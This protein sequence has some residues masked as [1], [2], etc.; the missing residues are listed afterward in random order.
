[1]SA[2]KIDLVGLLLVAI[3]VMVFLSLLPLVARI[4]A[5]TAVAHGGAA[6]ASNN[7]RFHPLQTFAV[8]VIWNP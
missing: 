6:T 8:T 5:W 4:D 1:M 3:A 2:T 7:V